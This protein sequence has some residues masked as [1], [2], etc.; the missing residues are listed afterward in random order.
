MR[1]HAELLAGTKQ[2]HNRALT[3]HAG[4]AAQLPL[5][6]ITDLKRVLDTSAFRAAL[7]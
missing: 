6:A 3:H 4:A 2:A 7:Q 1:S 5:P